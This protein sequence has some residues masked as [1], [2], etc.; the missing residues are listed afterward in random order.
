MVGK[1]LKLKYLPD[2]WFMRMQ[3][4]I[5][6][7]DLI[8]LNTYYD[9]EWAYL[10]GKFNPEVKIVHFMMDE[11]NSDIIDKFNQPD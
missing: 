3:Q 8:D 4:D 7:R 1:K 5:T 6:Q 2:S 9:G 10:G 11:F